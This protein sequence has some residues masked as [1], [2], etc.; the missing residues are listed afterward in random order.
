MNNSTLMYTKDVQALTPEDLAQIL[1]M[2][3]ATIYRKI[4]TGDIPAKK[5]G[6]DYRIPQTYI[7]YF[8]TGLD[9]DIYEKEK[10]DADILN[11]HQ[12]LLK[13]VRKSK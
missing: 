8:Q 2:S 10:I 3:K 6:K 13:E 11:K 7:Y 9:Y 4:R 1:K 12:N 5:I